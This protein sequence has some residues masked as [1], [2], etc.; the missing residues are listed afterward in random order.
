MTLVFAL[1]QAFYNSYESC[2]L[3]RVII[4]N[5]KNMEFSKRFPKFSRDK[6]TYKLPRILASKLL[7]VA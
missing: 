6:I 4:G 3:L 1:E 2:M 5:M 7:H